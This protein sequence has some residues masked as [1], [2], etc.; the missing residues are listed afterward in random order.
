MDMEVREERRWGWED[1]LGKERVHACLVPRTGTARSSW[2]NEQV[3]LNVAF[4]SR[5]AA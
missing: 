4:Q 1:P 2:T 3:W 5:K